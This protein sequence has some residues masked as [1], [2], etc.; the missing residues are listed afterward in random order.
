M[1]H[2]RSGK[3][4]HG[5]RV[6]DVRPVERLYVFELKHVSMHKSLLYLLVC[7]RDEEFVIMVCFLGKALREVYRHFQVHT[8]PEGLKKNAQLL[9]TAQGKHWDENLQGF[10]ELTYSPTSRN[11]TTGIVS[12]IPCHPFQRSPALSSGSRVPGSVWSL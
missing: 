10:K 8:V 6:V 5:R 4:H 3:D 2:S 9:S 7:P 12:V 1:Q 11:T